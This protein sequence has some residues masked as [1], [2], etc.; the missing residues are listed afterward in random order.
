MQEFV[1]DKGSKNLIFT[2]DLKNM[3]ALSEKPDLP[4]VK[5]MIE[6]FCTQSKEARFGNFIFGPPT[7]RMFHH[8]Q[9]ADTALEMFK[10]ESLNGFFDQPIS[11]QI[12]L[13]LLYKEK[14]Y[15]DVLDTFENIK[16]RQVFGGR[17]RGNVIVL[18]FA[19]CYK[20][21][22]PASFEYASNLWKEATSVGV[23]PVRRAVSLFA[24]LALKQNEPHVALEVVANVRQHH[25]I[26]VRSVKA[27]A[28]AHLKRFDDALPI[29]RSILEID[30]PLA[31][32]QTYPKDTIE[33]LKTL[34]ADCTSN[35]L[36]AE[37]NK[38]ISFIEKQGHISTDTLE[39]I[40]LSEIQPIIVDNNNFRRNDR[41]GSDF[42]GR[43]D[44]RDNYGGRRDDRDNYGG[45]RDDRGGYGNRRDDRGGYQKRDTEKYSRPGLHELN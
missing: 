37:F 17:Y 6:K 1:D 23:T 40:L 3:L 39:D 24:A 7:M 44:N 8:L 35:T 27:L 14:R 28:L 10:N 18:A 42:G 19:A 43:R 25:Y 4:L 21:N 2:E 9:D 33:D 38:T 13:D 32:K 31:N 36:L 12:L 11:Y 5:Q 45:R 16:Q 22:T 26:T 20:F 15:Q 41:D 30:N 29:V 34:F